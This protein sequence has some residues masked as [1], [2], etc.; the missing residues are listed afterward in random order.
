[1]SRFARMDADERQFQRDHQAA[2]SRQ[3]AEQKRADNARLAAQ[4]KQREAA[5]AAKAERDRIEAER[6]AELQSQRE[7]V[8]AAQARER[9]ERQKVAHRAAYI[10]S[11][12]DPSGFDREWPGML[13]RL[14]DEQTQQHVARQRALAT[15]TW[16]EQ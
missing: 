4:R 16:T 9:V 8:V 7:Q 15:D 3:L 10:A 6:V 2:V 12:G 1:M 14:I 11:G 13:K 5:A